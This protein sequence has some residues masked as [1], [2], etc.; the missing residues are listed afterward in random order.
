M[1]DRSST[2]F[3]QVILAVV[4]STKPRSLAFGDTVVIRH[5]RLRVPCT[6]IVFSL[7]TLILPVTVVRFGVLRCWRAEPSLAPG[8]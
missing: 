5:V 3:A 1:D 2:P 4:P 8:R 7:R 6:V